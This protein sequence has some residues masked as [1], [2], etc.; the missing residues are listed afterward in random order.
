MG[1]ARSWRSRAL[2]WQWQDIAFLEPPGSHKASRQLQL[3]LAQGCA[4]H[5][6]H[7]CLSSVP[8]WEPSLEH[9]GKKQRELE[10]ELPASFPRLENPSLLFLPVLMYQSLLLV[11]SSS[12]QLQNSAYAAFS[13]SCR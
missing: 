10:L 4:V 7:S 6:K 9:A 2:P 1:P 12:F 3:C 5:T 13:T 11:T 8:S